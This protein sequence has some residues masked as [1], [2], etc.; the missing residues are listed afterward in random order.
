MSSASKPQQ[1]EET[2]ERR[3]SRDS[4]MLQT[5]TNKRGDDRPGRRRGRDIPGRSGRGMCGSRSVDSTRE[6]K[7]MMASNASARAC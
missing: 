3:Y 5:S 2:V 4:F 6:M 7:A 1:R